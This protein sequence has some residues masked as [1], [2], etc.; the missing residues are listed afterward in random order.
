MRL[1]A[2]RDT[3]GPLAAAGLLIFVGIILE[4]RGLSAAAN[5]VQIISV[6][7]LAYSAMRFG[8]N[9]SASMPD[10]AAAGNDLAHVVEAEWREEAAARGLFDPEPMPV[11]WVPGDYALSDP[12]RKKRISGYSNARGQFAAS[13]RKL[14]PKRL[15]IL[16]T[17]GS[18]KTTLCMLLLIALLAERKPGTA[19]PVL[20]PIADWAPDRD[21]L[22]DWLARSLER[23]Y[24]M[25]HGDAAWSLVRD[26]QILPILDGLDEMPCG[27]RADA[28]RQLNRTL[29]DDD[30]IVISCRTDEYESAVRAGYKLRLAPVVQAEPLTPASVRVYL[31]R[32]EQVPAWQAVFKEID[33]HPD[34]CL[35]L[36]LSN[37]LLIELARI[38]FFRG[39]PSELIGMPSVTAIE[40][41]LL[42]EM[43]PA[44]FATERRSPRYGRRRA[45]RRDPED[46]K[47]WLGFL[48]A[49]GSGDLAWW[50]LRHSVPRLTM[51]LALVI[52]GALA[53][54]I[55][56]TL[57]LS[58]ASV[59]SIPA[60]LE[61]TVLLLLGIAFGLAR[62]PL[63]PARPGY[64]NLGS[65]GRTRQLLH[66][67]PT[68]LGFGL[69]IGYAFDLIGLLTGTFAYLSPA[70]NGP[71]HSSLVGLVAGIG[72]G[73]IRTLTLWVRLPAK[74]ERP[75]SPLS[76]LRSDR[77]LAVFDILSI[78]LIVG[79]IGTVAELVVG[80]IHSGI[81]WGII[82]FVA[83]CLAIGV[84]ASALLWPLN[85]WASFAFARLMLAL[86]G[87]IPWRL[88][89]FLQ[90]ARQVGVLRQTGTIYQF[91]HA[92]LQDRLASRYQAP[93]AIQAQSREPIIMRPIAASARSTV[94]MVASM[95]ILIWLSL[96]IRVVLAFVITVLIC[97]TILVIVA[98]RSFTQASPAEVRNRYVRHER[99]IPWNQVEHLF[100][101]EGIFGRSMAV[102]TKD[103]ERITLAAPRSVPFL[104]DPAFEH[105][106]T[107][108]AHY[109]STNDIA[110]STQKPHHSRITYGSIVVIVTLFSVVL[111]RPWQQ[112][113][114]PQPVAYNIPDACSVAPEFVRELG[115]RPTPDSRVGASGF[116]ECGWEGNGYQLDLSYFLYPN[117]AGVYGV[118]GARNDFSRNMS[119]QRDPHAISGLGGEAKWYPIFD[120]L[121]V[122]ATIVIANVSVDVKYVNALHAEE[123]TSVQ[124]RK[125]LALTR[126]AVARVRLK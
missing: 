95:G 13:F 34:G 82:T 3:T 124:L 79:V 92:R 111:A 37:P 85:S 91:R 89:R 103:K 8:R 52:S 43:I 88:M 93:V 31:S 64:A 58:L 100:L 121:G 109:A 4:Q 55:A 24:P 44:L 114:W 61:F 14:S 125:T 21:H 90:E 69:A 28:L 22:H 65:R 49:Q 48:A 107:R 70:L 78:T 66:L 35:A 30:S 72:I 110:V 120:G 117:A 108:M 2:W 32:V 7:P 67:L 23:D 16:G 81:G 11:H 27:T 75:S 15:V 106:V 51:R 25:L 99:T 33:D 9:R 101:I 59:E 12:I 57:F 126:V 77:L 113:W 47:R 26:R 1:R 18:G 36:A 50:R 42:D 54:L 112:P 86:R 105:S 84:A 46:A 102:E 38:V 83:L 56:A 76:A 19:V 10:S 115:L 119:R 40:E 41:R 122:E 71:L 97:Q 116:S 39:N 94:F 45:K 17:P 29:S 6:I 62:D 80:N 63:P 73:L 98:G 96:G 87:R 68:G 20:F 118:A 60:G 53:G 74:P 123:I 104:R 5:L